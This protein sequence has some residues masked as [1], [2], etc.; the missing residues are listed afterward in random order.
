LLS[1]VSWSHHWVWIVPALLAMVT[2]AVCTRS[3]GWI[4]TTVI[5]IATFS[6]GAHNFL[7]SG[8]GRELTWRTGQ[9]LL[10]DSYV[11]LTLMLLIAWAVPVVV[12]RPVS[13]QSGF[14]R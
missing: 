8:D 9:H 14:R 7:P 12:N 4:V 2:R 13:I 1:P 10:G 5:T 11:L 6:V 3:P